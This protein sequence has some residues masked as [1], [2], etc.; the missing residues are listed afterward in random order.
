MPVSRNLTAV[1]CL[2]KCL[3]WLGSIKRNVLL[4]LREGEQDGAKEEGC[5]YSSFFVY[6]TFLGP[7]KELLY[8]SFFNHSSFL[9]PFKLLRYIKERGIYAGTQVH[10]GKGGFD[11]RVPDRLLFRS[12]LRIRPLYLCNLSKDMNNN[13][14]RQLFK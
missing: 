1:L 13:P 14:F 7:F 4:V 3:R 6:S 11:T 2:F 10:S 5:S 8:S 9:R 12:Y